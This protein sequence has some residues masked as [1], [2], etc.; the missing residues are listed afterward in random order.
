MNGARAKL[1]A[2]DHFRGDFVEVLRRLRQE[3]GFRLIG[4][5]LM[6]E[7]FHLLIKCEPADSI[8]SILQELKRQRVART[9]SVGPRFV[10]DSS[11]IREGRK[12]KFVLHSKCR[13]PSEQVCAT[14]LQE[15]DQYPWCRQ[16][17]AR[18]TLP[19]TVHDESSYR[20]WQRRFYPFNVYS[21]RKRLEKLNYMH[22]NPVKRGLVSSPDQWVWSSFRFYCRRDSTEQTPNYRVR[23]SPRQ[24]PGV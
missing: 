6:P 19:A 12:A 13:R 3:T 11:W 17:L 10:L 14:W 2:S 16:M 22:G 8:S 1:F 23:L 4:W 15:N 20:V 9:C 24:T 21:E 5:V 7:H 18:L